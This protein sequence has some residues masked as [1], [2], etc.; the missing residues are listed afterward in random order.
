MKR[1]FESEEF[2]LKKVEQTKVS[3]FN[4]LP[5]DLIEEVFSYV[6]P[7]SHFDLL[8][9]SKRFNQIIQN[10]K[11]I[12]WKNMIKSISKRF[13]LHYYSRFLE[14]KFSFL[15]NIM[16]DPKRIITWDMYIDI[17]MAHKIQRY[18]FLLPLMMNGCELESMDTFVAFPNGDLKEFDLITK[19]KALE[20][21][22]TDQGETDPDVFSF[23][24]AKIFDEFIE[25]MKEGYGNIH[26]TDKSSFDKR[27]DGSTLKKI[28]NMNHLKD[29]LIKSG[30][31]HFSYQGVS[32]Y[33]QGGE[34]HS[35]DNLFYF[36]TKRNNVVGF[37]W[38]YSYNI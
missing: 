4:D 1:K 16:D 12:P 17:I 25:E 18:S 3:N 5:N 32:Y 7:F 11:I 35:S 34:L 15:H 24:G 21:M 8:K 38:S 37:G 36:V 14:G 30:V 9:I 26:Y 31:K 33:H 22:D 6:D 27:N 10:S 20:L 29:V 23:Q 19:K 2:S 13:Y 28:E